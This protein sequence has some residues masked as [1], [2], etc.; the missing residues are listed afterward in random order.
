MF[1]AIVALGSATIFPCFSSN[2]DA[3]RIPSKKVLKPSVLT[4]LF[5]SQHKIYPACVKLLETVDDTAFEMYYSIA[6][7]YKLP[8]NDTVFIDG[9]EFHNVLILSMLKGA[10]EFDWK[11]AYSIFYR[12]KDFENYKETNAG[13]TP[14]EI[15]QKLDRMR[16]IDWKSYY[17]SF[18]KNNND[19]LS[20]PL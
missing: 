11:K 16:K 3:E 1:W 15:I 8:L 12:N 4:K 9:K 20:F 13:T 18:G 7:K 2:N 17:K 6:D 5:F 19:Y 10:A 14:E